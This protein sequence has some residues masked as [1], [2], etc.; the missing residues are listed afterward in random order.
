MTPDTAAL[1]AL[2]DTYVTGWYLTAAEIRALCDAADEVERLRANGNGYLQRAHAAEAVIE[3]MRCAHCGEVGCDWI[4][5]IRKARAEMAE[6]ER[7]ASRTAHAALVADLRAKVAEA[8]T[9]RGYK[10]RDIGDAF[11]ATT[12]TD[13]LDDLTALLD[14]HAPTLTTTED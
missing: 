14:R 7:D 4:G 6:A 13:L 3:R 8:R 10:T 12:V 1:R 9:W 11:D 2:V 5:D